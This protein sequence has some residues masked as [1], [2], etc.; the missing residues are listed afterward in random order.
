MIEANFLLLR[1]GIVYYTSLG[2]AIK[3]LD[4]DIK[5][6][7]LKTERMDTGFTSSVHYSVIPDLYM[8]PRTAVVGKIAD[9]SSTRS[10]GRPRGT[11]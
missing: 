4:L 6:G 11:P 3:V 5:G 2:S 8:T 1:K 10:L 7:Y 9:T